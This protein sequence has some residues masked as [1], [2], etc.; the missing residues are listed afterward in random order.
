MHSDDQ[1]RKGRI[2]VLSVKYHNEGIDKHLEIRKRNQIACP[3]PIYSLAAYGES[4]II[5]GSEGTLSKIE[6]VRNEHGQWKFE[7]LLTHRVSST[8]TQITVQENKGLIWVSSTRDALTVYQVKDT[9]VP[10]LQRLYSDDCERAGRSHVQIEDN[11]FLATDRDEGLLGL[12]MPPDRRTHTNFTK[13]FEAYLPNSIAT[14]RSGDLRAPWKPRNIFLP[15]IIRP[16]IDIIGTCFDGSMYHFTILDAA[17]TDL[18]VYLQ[19]TYLRV[20]YPK[21]RSKPMHRR[22]QEMLKDGSM[23]HVDGGIL[24]QALEGGL[25]WL[26]AVARGDQGVLEGLAVRLFRTGGRGRVIREG[27]TTMELVE[28]Y[29]RQLLG[30]IVL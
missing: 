20:A 13:T 3:E 10:L 28:A 1:P 6:L 24:A 12:W 8:P 27:M 14:L 5:Y 25:G 18:L 22:E 15:G 19:Q 9:P 2:L 11:F 16:D 30:G 26:D 4:S 29:L 17:A 21:G 7:G 23:R